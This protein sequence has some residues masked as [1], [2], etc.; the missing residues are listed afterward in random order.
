ML[1]IVVHQANEYYQDLHH[2]APLDWTVHHIPSG[3]MDI[4]VCLKAMNQ[5]SNT[6]SASHV[7]N[8]MLFLDG[9]DSRFDDRALIQMQIK[10]IQTFILKAGDSINGQPDEN[11]PN[12]KMNAIYNILKSKWMPKYGTTSFQP[13]HMNS[14]LVETWKAFTV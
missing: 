9:H 6:C 12:S 8:K 2:N 5:W 10:N 4:D 13:H 1:A 11:G 7:N 14:V 3:Y